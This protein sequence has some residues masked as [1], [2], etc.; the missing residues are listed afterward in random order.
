MDD[1]LKDI[2]SNLNPGIDQE[3][4]LLYL[5][6]KLSAEQQHAVEKQLIEDEF[7]T[8]AIEGLQ[9]IKDKQ[10][11]RSV[12]DQLNRDLKKKT[13][14]NRRLKEKRNIQLDP[15][16]YMIIILILILVFISYIVIHKL[17]VH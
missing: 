4:L 15:W 16:F 9:N 8:E 1:N 6:G 3:T 12:L 5:Q 17:L 11:I 2:L 10:K 14:K 7:E 13:E